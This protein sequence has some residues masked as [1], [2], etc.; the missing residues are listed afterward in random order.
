VIERLLLWVGR[1]ILGR[2]SPTQEMIRA[3]AAFPAHRA[4][5]EGLRSDAVAC[6]PSA[7][8][9]RCQAHADAARRRAEDDGR[10]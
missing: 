2:P 8:C 1:R 3:S 9:P 10:W 4:L 6:R 7:L 5:E